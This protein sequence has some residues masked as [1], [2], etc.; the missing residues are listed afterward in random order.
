MITYKTYAGKSMLKV[1]EYLRDNGEPQPNPILSVAFVAEDENGKILGL[2]VVQSMP[3]VEP[4]HGES[5]EIL[6]RLFE[7]TEEFIKG[8]GAP[9][10][11]MHTSHRAMQGM[12]RLKGA[13]RVEDPFFDWRAS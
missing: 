13:E 11:L 1:A 4:F 5:G 7:M 8:S 2:S 10:V 12:L 9:R 6:K 3:F